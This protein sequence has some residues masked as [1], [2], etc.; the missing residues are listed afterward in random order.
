MHRPWCGRP[1]RCTCIP[2][3]Q[4][5]EEDHRQLRLGI[6]EEAGHIGFLTHRAEVVRCVRTHIRKASAVV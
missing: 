2:S 6:I 3:V 4:P 1:G 5:R